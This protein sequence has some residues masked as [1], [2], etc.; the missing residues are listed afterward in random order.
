[1]IYII[2]TIIGIIATLIVKSTWSQKGQIIF[3]FSVLILGL[4]LF[5]GITYLLEETDIIEKGDS[6]FLTQIPW[7]EIGL[8]FSMIAGMAAK[9]FYDA[10]GTGRRKK[11]TF[12]KWRFL[13][14]M[15]VSPLVFGTVY[16]S[17][18][19]IESIVLVLLFAFQN[20]FFWQTVMNK[21]EGRN[22][23]PPVKA[24]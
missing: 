17:M 11:I 4:L 9:Y 13:K 8:Y 20:G 3:I 21:P 18:D 16:A 15:F 1:M 24:S 2:L 7:L 23:T 14:P 22:D 12:R 6:S 10:I 5:F 19:K